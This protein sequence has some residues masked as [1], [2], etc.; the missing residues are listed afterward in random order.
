MSAMLTW[1]GGT[2]TAEQ[3]FVRLALA[4][5]DAHSAKRIRIAE[6]TSVPQEPLIA[7]S[8]ALYT[9]QA[10]DPNRLIIVAYLP[11]ATTFRRDAT[12]EWLKIGQFGTEALNAAF[13]S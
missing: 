6:D 4:L 1:T 5:E 8:R 12:K 3:E 11:Y 7:T 13:A 10:T 9:A 2:L